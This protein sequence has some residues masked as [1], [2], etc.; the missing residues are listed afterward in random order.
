MEEIFLPVLSHFKNGNFWTASGGRMQYKVVPGE[1]LLTAEVW[2]GPWNHGD[3]PMEEQ[4]E[5]PLSEEGLAELRVWLAD[6]R[7]RINAR[8]TRSL[9]ETIRM[10]D[11]YRA[12]RA[13]PEA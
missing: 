10:R 13:A 3:S 7:E 5:F 2:E 11:E 12:G 9:E 8:P 6:W 4:K 1:E